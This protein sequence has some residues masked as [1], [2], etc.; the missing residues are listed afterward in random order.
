MTF[1]QKYRK[2]SQNIRQNIKNMN[3]FHKKASLR[4]KKK[5]LIWIVYKGFRCEVET[6]SLVFKSRVR[7]ERNNNFSDAILHEIEDYPRTIK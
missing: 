3:V 6:N 1:L 4:H 2:A 7:K 5:I